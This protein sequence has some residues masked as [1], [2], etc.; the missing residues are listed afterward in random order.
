ME[1]SDFRATLDQ[2]VYCGRCKAGGWPIFWEVKKSSADW[3]GCG[4]AQ[5]GVCGN[6]EMGAVGTSDYAHSL[7]QTWRRLVMQSIGATGK[8]KKIK[9]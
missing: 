1:E 5:C 2:V 7:A 8:D 6:F 9:R 4:I 3:Y